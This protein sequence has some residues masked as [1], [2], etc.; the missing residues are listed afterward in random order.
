MGF[1]NPQYESTTKLVNY[2]LN[3]NMNCVGFICTTSGIYDVNL[4]GKLWDVND[5]NLIMGVVNES[6]ESEWTR[7]RYRL[8][9]AKKLFEYVIVDVDDIEE[10]Y[11]HIDAMFLDLN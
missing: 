10:G 2:A 9:K 1:L 11:K 5:T 6:T 4:D 7:L 3:K 8:K